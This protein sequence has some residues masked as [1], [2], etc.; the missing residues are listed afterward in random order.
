MDIKI[1]HFTFLAVF[2]VSVSS[3]ACGQGIVNKSYLQKVD[4]PYL[5]QQQQLLKDYFLCSCINYGF[6]EDS[7][8]LKDASLIIYTEL[9]DYDYNDIQ[10][11][12]QFAKKKNDEGEAMKG[13]RSADVKANR[14]IFDSCIEYYRGKELDLLIKSMQIKK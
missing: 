3:T 12:K 9:L 10:K 13:E 7:L 1:S 14:A 6:K 8:F 2:L 11:V 4:S 5:T